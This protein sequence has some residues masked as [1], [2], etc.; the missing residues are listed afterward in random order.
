MPLTFVIDHENRLICSKGWGVL[1]EADM[2]DAKQR[3]REQ[4]EFDPMYREFCDFTGVTDFQLTAKQVQAFARTSP[5]AQQARRA[6]V[7]SSDVVF[8]MVRMYGLVG[9]RDPENH[10]IFRDFPSA[11][12]WFGLSEDTQLARELMADARPRSGM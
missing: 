1:T 10:R 5:F 8:G 6:V 11:L 2:A 9:D 3:L 4:T 7:V 12:R